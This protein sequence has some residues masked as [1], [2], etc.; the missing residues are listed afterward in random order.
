M[1]CQ[2]ASADRSDVA[3]INF[4]MQ[5]DGTGQNLA[6]RGSDFDTLLPQP[7]DPSYMRTLYD[8]GYQHR[9]RTMGDDLT[10]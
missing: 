5:R 9:R 10:Y 8:L 4:T 7:F 1:A 2:L 6:Y 3:K